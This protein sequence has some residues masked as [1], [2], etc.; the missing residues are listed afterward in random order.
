MLTGLPMPGQVSVTTSTPGTGT[1]MAIGFYRLGE[2]VGRESRHSEF[3]Q[4][5]MAHKD[6]TWL[7]ETV[8]K[9]VC[10][11]LNSSEGGTLY[12]GV[13]DRGKFVAVFDDNCVH[14]CVCACWCVCICMQMFGHVC[15]IACFFLLM[16]RE[17]DAAFS[18]FVQK[19]YDP[20]PTRNSVQDKHSLL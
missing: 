20:S 1:G 16:V 8:G 4:G 18:L 7:Q 6:R 13:N 17:P 12:I 11:F 10:G 9:Y 2:T 19:G 5:G 14:A 3:K 15:F